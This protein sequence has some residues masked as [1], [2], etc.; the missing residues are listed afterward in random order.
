MT[1]EDFDAAQQAA[2]KKKGAAYEAP[3]WGGGV[4]QVV[5]C[6]EGSWTAGWQ[7]TCVTLTCLQMR[8][9][10][11]AAAAAQRE[12]A[13]PFART[14][15]TVDEDLKLRG[16]HQA[17]RTS[18]SQAVALQVGLI[19]AVL[20]IVYALAIPWHTWQGNN[21]QHLHRL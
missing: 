4:K 15:D 10:E 3:E 9:R 6:G 7:Q 12:A 5:G 8:D 14:L 17:Q 11:E 21:I 20:Q 16:R 19:S 18:L 1:K 2:T 13:M